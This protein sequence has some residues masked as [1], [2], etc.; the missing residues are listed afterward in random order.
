MARRTIFDRVR[1]AGHRYVATPEWREEFDRDLDHSH[2]VA[3]VQR[4]DGHMSAHWDAG[5]CTIG[6][7][8]AHPMTVAAVQACAEGIVASEVAECGPIGQLAGSR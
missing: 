6:A 4:V 1:E 8:D 3:L 5:Q 7:E 2:I